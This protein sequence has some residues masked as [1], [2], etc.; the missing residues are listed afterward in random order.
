MNNSGTVGSFLRKT[1]RYRVKCNNAYKVPIVDRKNMDEDYFEQFRTMPLDEA[2]AYIEK[3][4]IIEEPKEG[5]DNY[6]EE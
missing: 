1:T 2:V 3:G 5:D 6:G 4:Y